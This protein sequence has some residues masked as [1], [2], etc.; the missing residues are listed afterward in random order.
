M[1]VLQL[2]VSGQELTENTWNQQLYIITYWIIKCSI[3]SK[4]LKKRMTWQM[5]RHKSSII[6]G[7]LVCKMELFFKSEMSLAGYK[8][9]VWVL[10]ISGN[11]GRKY[12]QTWPHYLESLGLKFINLV[13]FLVQHPPL[14]SYTLIFSFFFFI[15]YRF[16]NRILYYSPHL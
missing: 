10:G 9:S 5:E 7:K 6:T 12:D 14:N 4:I 8:L 11:Q 13:I 1:Q 15:L 3:C 16:L 2:N